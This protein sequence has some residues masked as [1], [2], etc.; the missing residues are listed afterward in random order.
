[1]T[2]NGN[3]LSDF[4]KWVGLFLMLD[5]LSRQWQGDLR[6]KKFEAPGLF[7]LA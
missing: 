6:L 1:M 3:D 4:Q 2:G 7:L 5:G